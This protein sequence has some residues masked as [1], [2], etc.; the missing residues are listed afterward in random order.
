MIIAKILL[1]MNNGFSVKYWQKEYTPNLLKLS[2]KIAFFS[3]ASDGAFPSDTFFLF[4]GQRF[5]IVWAKASKQERWEE[6]T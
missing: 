6:R 1:E 5:I 2:L 3:L 4:S